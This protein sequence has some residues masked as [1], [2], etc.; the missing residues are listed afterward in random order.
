M[1]SN[2]LLSPFTV[3]GEDLCCQFVCRL[4]NLNIFV[5]DEVKKMGEA[6]GVSV[7]TQIKDGEVYDVI[8]S[9]AREY[10]S[11]IIIMGSHG[12]T[13][14]RRLLMGSVAERVIGYAPCPVL[15]IKR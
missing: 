3:R 12:R 9:L 13:G 15:V 5:V 10:N 1:Q 8:T 2:Y 14:I 6:Q 7:E 11:G 4:P